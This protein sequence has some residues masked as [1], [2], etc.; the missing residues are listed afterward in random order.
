MVAVSFVLGFALTYMFGYEDEVEEV[1]G[2]ISEAETD[3]LTER[4]SNWYCWFHLAKVLSK[5]Q[6]LVT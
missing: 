4:S 6:S 3:R 5:H 1:S 2:A